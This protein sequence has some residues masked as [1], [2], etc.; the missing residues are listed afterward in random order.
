MPPLNRI[1]AAIAAEMKAA[2]D[3][4][5]VADYIPPL[6]CVPPEKFGIAVVLADG[7]CHLGGDADE[8]FSIQSIS[9]VFALTLALGAVGDQLWE[10]VGREPSGS[11]RRRSATTACERSATATER[12]CLPRSMPTARPALGSSAISDGGRPPPVATRPSPSFAKASSRM[13]GRAVPTVRSQSPRFSA[14]PC[15]SDLRRVRSMSRV[16]S[17]TSRRRPS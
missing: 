6:A 17:S 4:G 15:R 2:P 11:A 3:R 1:V 14:G 10:R 16:S 13:S 12:C 8:P 9:K 7:T 5:K